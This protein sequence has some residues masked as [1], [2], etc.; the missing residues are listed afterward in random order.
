M[1]SRPRRSDISEF[2]FIGELTS[3]C[4]DDNR[5]FE[6]LEATYRFERHS[7]LVDAPN[8]VCNGF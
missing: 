3:G 7:R 1:C 5:P 6:T 2:R 8:S 4:D